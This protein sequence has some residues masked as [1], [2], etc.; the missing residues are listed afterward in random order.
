MQ[1]DDVCCLYCTAQRAQ[2][3]IQGRSSP[4]KSEGRG[5]VCIASCC[6]LR[7]DMT[8]G[9][10]NHRVCDVMAHDSGDSNKTVDC[11]G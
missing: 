6:V 4:V 3:E 7:V 11:A 5:C 2:E 9:D 10:R 8:T 1:E